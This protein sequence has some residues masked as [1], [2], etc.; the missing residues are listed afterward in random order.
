MK[1]RPTVGRGSCRAFRNWRGNELSLRSPGQGTRPTAQTRFCR[2]GALTGRPTLFPWVRS[3][4]ARQEP[5]PTAA[6]IFIQALTDF[7]GVGLKSGR[8]FNTPA[9]PP[10]PPTSPHP[11]TG[12]AEWTALS[13]WRTLPHGFQ[14]TQEETDLHGVIHVL[15][16]RPARGQ[17]RPRAQLGRG[18][19]WFLARWQ[20]VASRSEALMV[21]VGFSPRGNGARILASRSDA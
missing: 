7:R 11:R 5:R 16:Q 18:A 20:G 12:V 13:T 8:G 3:S 17:R 4:E 9:P 14:E 6:G 15:R 19:V 2:P 1:S 10:V 21:A